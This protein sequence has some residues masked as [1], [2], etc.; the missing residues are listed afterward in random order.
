[1]CIDFDGVRTFTEG[2]SNNL[3]A[4]LVILK[5]RAWFKNHI[6]FLNI[7][8]Y[9]IERIFLTISDRLAQNNFAYLWKSYIK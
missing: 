5:G 8:E 1:V 2:A 9:T 3:L 7:D 4:E 6:R